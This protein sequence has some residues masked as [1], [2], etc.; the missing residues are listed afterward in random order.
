M[1]A[2]RLDC[3]NRSHSVLGPLD[4]PGRAEH[5]LGGLRLTR[6]V[7]WW[8]SGPSVAEKV[9]GAGGVGRHHALGF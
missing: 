9:E 3:A 2:A 1:G 5:L 4:P 7:P 6:G 8:S